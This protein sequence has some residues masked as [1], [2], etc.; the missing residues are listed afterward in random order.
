MNRIL[1]N[2]LLVCARFLG[3][4]AIFRAIHKNRVRVLLYH[5]V[6]RNKFEPTRWTQLDIDSFVWQMKHIKK[7]FNS[8]A[9][10]SLGERT[11]PGNAVVI[12]FD[13]G[14]QN[15]FENAFP[16]LKELNLMAVCFVLPELSQKGK[17][18]WPDRV[19]EIFSNPTC[20][21]I[22]LTEFDLPQYRYKKR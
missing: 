5:G 8:M 17:C 6:T 4:N 10:S 18:I 19:H 11:H 2:V 22:D 3:F 12:N 7:H 9:A 14:L 20:E 13:D 1:K 21:T 15:V 16:I